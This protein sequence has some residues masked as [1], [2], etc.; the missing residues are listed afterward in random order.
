MPLKEKYFVPMAMGRHRDTGGIPPAAA[1]RVLYD[2]A[3]VVILEQQPHR[4]P[5]YRPARRGALNRKVGVYEEE[6]PTWK[7]LV[8]DNGY[9]KR[10]FRASGGGPK[11]QAAAIL[12]PEFGKRNP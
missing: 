3:T 11:G 9:R 7:S 5:R 2:R 1:D 4:S 10:R 8:T 12:R 6:F